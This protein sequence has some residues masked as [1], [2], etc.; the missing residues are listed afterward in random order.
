MDPRDRP[1]HRGRSGQGGRRVMSWGAHR[2]DA[3][4][5]ARPVDVQER[6]EITKEP[7]VEFDLGR[8]LHL[9]WRAV[10]IG[11]LLGWFTCGLLQCIAGQTSG[12]NDWRPV[13][14]VAGGMLMIAFLL[15]S[16][17]QERSDG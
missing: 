3:V 6:T 10:F 9:P 1:R 15:M 17:S 8:S 14:V 11:F 12:D 7:L 2:W 4:I 5:T 13:T 16:D